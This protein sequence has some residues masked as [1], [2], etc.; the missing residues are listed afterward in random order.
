MKMDKDEVK[1]GGMGWNGMMGWRGKDRMGQEG[2][3]SNPGKEEKERRK[4]NG[5]DEKER[6]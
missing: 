5:V 6:S 3:L 2:E 4:S 1:R